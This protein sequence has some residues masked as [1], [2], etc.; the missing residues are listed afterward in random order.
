MKGGAIQYITGGPRLHD[1]SSEIDQLQKCD[2][3]MRVSKCNV[4]STVQEV[5]FKCSGSLTP[6]K[7]N[8]NLH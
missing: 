4:T 2:T 7:P 8:R 5:K 1:D 3:M 6:P